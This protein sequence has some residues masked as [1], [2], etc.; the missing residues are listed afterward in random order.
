MAHQYHIYQTRF[1]ATVSKISIR[2]VK[3]VLDDV[4]SG[5]RKAALIGSFST[6]RLAASIYKR[7]PIVADRRVFGTVG[8]RLKYAG[9]VEHGAE[10]H[11]IFPKGAHVFRFGD[12]R[13]PQLK[14][15]W[16]GKTVYTPH[17]PMSRFTVDISHPGQ[18]AKHFLRNAAIKAAKK[19]RMHFIPGPGS[20]S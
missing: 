17:V 4:Q 2:K 10:I 6:G 11:A 7:G 18:P 19:H 13:K 15:K 5:A 1:E 16:R 3:K 14:F 8:S 9:S 12:R 20:L